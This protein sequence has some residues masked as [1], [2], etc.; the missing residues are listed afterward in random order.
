[1]AWP[2]KPSRLQ[3]VQLGAACCQAALCLPYADASSRRHGSGGESKLKDD[4]CTLA[5]RLAAAQISHVQD[6]GWVTPV[7]DPRWHPGMIA[8]LL[9]L[10]TQ[11]NTF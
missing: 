2:T 4:C 1:M 8:R 11:G 9:M 3:T 5:E 10:S 6:P 7:A